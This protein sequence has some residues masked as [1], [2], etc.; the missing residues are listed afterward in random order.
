MSRVTVVGGGL[1]GLISAIEAAERGA[2]VDLFEAREALGGRARSTDPP[3]IADWG[4]H[5][6][7]PP[8]LLWSWLEARQLLPPI[9]K[10]QR[11]GYRVVQD[12]KL[13]ILSLTYARAFLTV[14]GQAP[15]DVDFT[16]WAT[17]KA[18]QSA[19]RAATS[20]LIAFTYDHDPGRLSARF[21]HE[22]YRRVVA[23]SLKV[24]YVV[25]GWSRLVE[26]LER[27][28]ES[29][30]VKIHTGAHVRALPDPPVIIATDPSNARL[31]LGEFSYTTGRIA[32]LDLAIR[33]KRMLPTV[34]FS[35]D[36]PMVAVRHS[37]VDRSLVPE[38]EELIEV[39]TGFP[40]SETI[41]EATR[42]MEAF[43]DISFKGWRERTTWRRSLSS[44]AA[45]GA[46]DLPGHTWQDRPSIEFDDGIFLAGDWVRAPGYLSDVACASATEA[47]RKAVAAATKLTRRPS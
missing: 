37:S 2:R 20:L 8:N 35:L 14:R 38:G 27:K 25:G 1:A 26:S 21:C 7:Y 43:L 39:A 29:L 33:T 45:A 18:G 13:K 19:A 47:A 30:G 15:V 41:E 46:V 11:R 5:A 40:P 4:P 36:E 9:V 34:V 12:G 31:L 23:P 32:V 22:R 24:R 6:L 10:P 42:R 16:T 28:V 44:H 3:Y 17:A